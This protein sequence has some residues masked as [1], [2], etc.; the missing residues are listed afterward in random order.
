MKPFASSNAIARASPKA[1]EFVV[2]EVGARSRGQASFC[3]LS[4]IL[5]SADFAIVDLLLLVRDTIC[6]HVFLMMEL[7]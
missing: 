1:R 3:D 7:Y 5:I 6:L 4:S 2:E